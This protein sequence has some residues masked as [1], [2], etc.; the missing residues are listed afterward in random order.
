MTAASADEPFDFARRVE[1]APAKP[2]VYLMKDREGAVVYVGKA[3]SL[4]ARLRQYLNRQDERF[5]VHLL[6]SVLGDIELVLTASAKEA[7]LLENEL[8]KQHQPRYNVK[9]KDDKRFIHL[10][11]GRKHAYPRL[12]VVRQ[13][14][15]D[16][17][18][19]FG[20]Y[21]SASSARMTLRQVNRYFKLRTCSDQSF[22][23][24]SRPC[25]EYQIKRCPA[26]CVL[27]VDKDEYAGHIE[28]VAMFLDGRRAALM[29]ELHQRMT[30]AAT[31]EDFEHAAMLRDQWRA[32]ERS[33]EQQ[34]TVMLGN[35]RD[36]DAIG[37]FREGG[38]VAI[39]VLRF[40]LGTLI[41]SEG[42]ALKDQEFPDSEVL[43]GFLGRFYSG[44]HE[45]PD[46]V[47]LPLDV[48]APDATGE[49]LTD[50][51]RAR[52]GHTRKVTVTTPQRGTRKRLVDVSID[53]AKQVFEDRLRTS[54]SRELLTRL[55]SKLG[56]RNLPARIECYDISNISGT[57]PVAS[58]VVFEDGEPARGEYRSFRIRSGDTPNDFAMMYEVLSRRFSRGIREGT[59]LPDLVMVDGG[60][61]Q[62]K[63]AVAA[64]G[65]LGVHDLDIIGLAKA[66]TQQGSD[67]ARR[68]R[69]PERVFLPNKQHPLVL[70]QTSD[71]VHLLTRLRDEAHR[72][73]IT[74]HRKLRGK[75]TLASALDDIAGIGPARRKALL[76]AFGSVGKI[77]AAPVTDIAAVDG[78]GPELAA[79]IKAGLSGD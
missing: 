76:V 22:R 49:W 68:K 28:H 29:D 8:I 73:A 5:F 52:G 42:Y 70:P 19:Y 26:P 72:F 41:G 60:V 67:D 6:A 35:R 1:L 54:G 40:R 69:S 11:I 62:L 43:D 30:A 51:R 24:R 45:I 36:T 2:G 57:D 34:N 13:T 74:F 44:G 65:D 14:K 37:L 18:R 46:D 21:A 78:I 33:L 47:L 75:R 23:N 27:P 48:D 9:L 31:N 56:L 39:A 63:M 77:E 3:K 10:R 16:N 79:A 53:N 66:R 71:E 58:M 7:L 4:R 55:Q 17:A 25:L 32:V 15:R 20:P 50:E 12:E 38:R 59:A 64:L 61:G